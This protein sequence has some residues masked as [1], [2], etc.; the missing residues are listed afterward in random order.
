MLSRQDRL[1]S[2]F[3]RKRS[4]FGT[5]TI[6]AQPLSPWEYPE[7]VRR[8]TKFTR[9]SFVSFSVRAIAPTLFSSTRDFFW[10]NHSESSRALN[11]TVVWLW[12]AVTRE[13]DVALTMMF[14]SSPYRWSRLTP[15][16][17]FRTCNAAWLFNV[18][19]AETYAGTKSERDTCGKRLP[20]V[21]GCYASVTTRG[22]GN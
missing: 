16:V 12:P 10:N 17:E 9:S 2:K 18:F 3:D 1:S 5:H 19:D 20:I 7:H 21:V 13:Y 11:R 22:W 14:V 6:R 8:T 15:P 4:Y